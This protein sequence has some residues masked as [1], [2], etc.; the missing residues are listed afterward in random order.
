MSSFWETL[1]VY[2]V[3]MQSTRLDRP[4][5]KKGGVWRKRNI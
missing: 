1:V 4:A 2:F 5:G 3:T